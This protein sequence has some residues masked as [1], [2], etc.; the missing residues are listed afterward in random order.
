MSW[1]IKITLLYSSF[2]ALMLFMVWKAWGERFDLVSEDYYA[3]ELAFQ[4][5][6]D[7][8][9]RATETGQQWAFTQTDGGLS[10]S[11]NTAKGNVAVQL[12]RPSDQRLDRTYN[13]NGN[14]TIPAAD[15]TPGKYLVKIEW[16]HNGQPL[17][18]EHVVVIK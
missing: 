1:S 10:G 11:L 16:Q 8:A 6:I 4:S 2:V 15:L 12:F 5:K 13:F 14:F 3:Q 18:N 17:Y 9:Q 7:M